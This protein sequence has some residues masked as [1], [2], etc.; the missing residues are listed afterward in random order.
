MKDAIGKLREFV[1]NND[2][3]IQRSSAFVDADTVAGMLDEIEKQYIR[4]PRDADGITVRPGDKLLYKNTMLETDTLVLY[5]TE[6]E[7]DDWRAHAQDG[8]LMPPYQCTHFDEVVELCPFCGS[9]A[10]VLGEPLEQCA[11][12]MCTKCGASM[13][14]DKALE[15][16][17]LWNARAAY[18]GDR[19]FFLP[20]PKENLIDMYEDEIAFNYDDAGNIL[21]RKAVD[22][23]P[24]DKAIRE[25]GEQLGKEIMSGIVEVF[26]DMLQ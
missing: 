13:R 10:L 20:K 12:V 11:A 16:V 22:Y 23:I 6:G 15:A 14:A 17:R 5:G 4:L 26:S 19:Y 2:T 21:V 24:N 3:S 25:W 9:S 8:I 18:Q 7:D 1:S